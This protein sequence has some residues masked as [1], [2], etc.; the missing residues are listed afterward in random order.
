MYGIVEITGHQY[1]VAPGEIIDVDKLGA[2]EAGA[3]I[4]LDRVLYIGGEK[5]LVGL[6]TVSGAKVTVKVIRHDKA[7]KILVFKRRPG[8]YQKKRGHRTHF[9][10]LLITERSYSL[11]C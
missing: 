4:E 3:I 7:R 10:A 2:H 8:L 5:P 1:R 11:L 6:P 9:T